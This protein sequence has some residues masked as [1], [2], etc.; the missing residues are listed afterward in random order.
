MMTQF[1]VGME[2]H[3]KVEAIGMVARI[4]MVLIY[5]FQESVPSPG[6]RWDDDR[7]NR[8][9]EKRL[10]RIRWVER[11]LAHEFTGIRGVLNWLA[12]RTRLT[13]KALYSKMVVEADEIMESAAEATRARR[14]R[15][16][17][18]PG[19][20]AP[21]MMAMGEM[22]YML[23]SPEDI[24]RRVVDGGVRG[25]SRGDARGDTRED[26]HGGIW[27]DSPS[28]AERSQSSQPEPSQPEPPWKDEDYL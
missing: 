22:G 24:R 13:G 28:Q 8:E 5:C 17:L 20:R 21:G 7:R 9:V 18:S 25:D 23:E 3:E 27:D 15:R 26:L 12:G 2:Y 6:G 11:E 1:R 19:E 16:E 10:A 4:E 14:E